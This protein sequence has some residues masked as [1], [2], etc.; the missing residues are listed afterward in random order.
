MTDVQT[1][2]PLDT[3]VI[4]IRSLFNFMY[5]LGYTADVDSKSG[6]FVTDLPFGQGNRYIGF[7]TAAKLHNLPA[8]QWNIDEKGV[9]F[10]S[11][12][13]LKTGFSVIGVKLAFASKLVD[14]VKLC[15]TKRGDLITMD[16]MIKPLN[17]EVESF[18]YAQ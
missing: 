13:Q 9:V 8:A 2:Q 16:P 3:T 6:R 10:P 1:F 18:L 7:A 15:V 12:V 11:V 5:A 14:Q 17:K 4:Q